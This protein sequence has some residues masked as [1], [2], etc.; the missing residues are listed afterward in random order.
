MED[1]S[2]FKVNLKTGEIEIE[3][4]EEFI[5][6]QILNLQKVISL[7]SPLTEND[8]E[9]E[10]KTESELGKMLDQ[11]G[12]EPDDKTFK[13]PET[14]GEF[15]HLMRTDISETDKALVAGYFVQSKSEKNDFKTIEVS[16]TLKAHGIKLSNPGTFV[17]GLANNKYVFQTRKDGVLNYMRVSQPGL[18]YLKTLLNK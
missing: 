1:K 15:L 2:R 4:S 11:S 8:N 7:F 13:I 9:A 18:E 5:E 14:F 6:K 3:G 16:K 12:K 10:E 17:K